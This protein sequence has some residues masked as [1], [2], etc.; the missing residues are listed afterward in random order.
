MI[1]PPHRRTH[2]ILSAY[3]CLTVCLASCSSTPEEDKRQ[4][5]MNNMRDM[6]QDQPVDQMQDLPRDLTGDQTPDTPRDMRDMI[7][8]TC[9]DLQQHTSRLWPTPGELTY[10]QHGLG[11]LSLG[12][13][14]IV[15]GPQGQLILIDVGNDSN[16]DDIMETLD[17]LIEHLNKT[18]GYPTRRPRHV[19]TIILTHFHA[20]HTDGL[21]DLLSK[22]DVDTIIH[23]G[24]VDL[25]AAANDKTIEKF[26]RTIQQNRAATVVEFCASTQPGCV[27]GV[28]DKQRHKAMHC[29]GLL[30]G[31]LDAVVAGKPTTSSL[32]EKTQIRFVAANASINGH[33]YESD[34]AAISDT[35]SNG[36]NARSVVG[37]IEHG[38]FRLMFN[39]D[40][41]GGGKQTAN[42]EAF[43]L[44]HLPQVSDIDQLGIDVLHLGHHG[45]S[46]SSSKPWLDALLPPDGCSRNAV[47]GISRAHLGSP[48]R[49]VLTRLFEQNR[50]AQGFG[51]STEGHGDQTPG[52]RTADGGSV[53]IQTHDGGKTYTVQTMSEA[54]QVRQSATYHAIKACAHKCRATR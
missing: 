27:N 8:N 35:E 54:G 44:Q 42:V 24:F 38:A 51:W 46:T 45:R 23:R 2:A 19:N 22:V 20:D 10:I 29:D 28:W 40:L 17:L 3:A 21:E 53:I 16:D 14:A 39:G 33:A 26:C 7:D 48:Q 43:I 13:A 30:K 41:T 5:S 49:D 1:N 18:P 25:T 47:M 50:L 12:E 6:A 11:G 4:P 37:V 32:G 31:P 36:E 34:V 52:H 15:V 9:E